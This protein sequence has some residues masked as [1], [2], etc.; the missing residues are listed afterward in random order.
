MP[1]RRGVD[2]HLVVR[3]LRTQPRQ[4]HEADELVDARER[5]REEL[6]DVLVVEV[7]AARGEDAQ[8]SLPLAQPT[9]KRAI[10]VQLGG[11]EP[12]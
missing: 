2:D 12:A 7:R 11:V 1:G 6:V 3:S 4:L 9:R 8:R 10:R 5:L